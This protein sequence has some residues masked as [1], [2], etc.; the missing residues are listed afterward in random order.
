VIGRR[1]FITSTAAVLGNTRF[2]IAQSAARIPRIGVLLTLSP[3]ASQAQLGVAGETL[4][5]LGYVEGRNIVLDVRFADTASG[6]ADHAADFISRNVDVLVTAGT[7]EVLALKRLTNRVPIV[8]MASTDPVQNGIVTSLARPGGNITG[9][10]VL[11]PEL[12]IKQLQLLKEVATS[13]SRIAVMGDPKNEGVKLLWT[14]IQAPAQAL[15]IRIERVAA[16]P[17]HQLETIFEQ[18]R[19]SRSE[20]LVVIADSFLFSNFGAISAFAAKERLPSVSIYKEFVTAGGLMAHG[21]SLSQMTRRTVLYVDK[22]LKGAKPA[23][24]PIEQPVAFELTIN[25]K[26]AKALGLTIPPSLLLRADQVIE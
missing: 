23:E 5:E 24:L 20:G 14:T 15:G 9:N 26:T 10:A 16:D 6:F 25:V 21:P 17:S 11:V 8:M 4:K 7:S 12:T 1:A 22:V 19:R 3:G 18:V 13:A 2:A